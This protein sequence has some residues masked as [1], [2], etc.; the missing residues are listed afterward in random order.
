[1]TYLQ[2]IFFALYAVLV[3]STMVTVLLDNRQPAKAIAWILV[4]MFLPVIGIILYIFFGQNMR[5]ERLISGK[6]VGEV[7]QFPVSDT[8]TVQNLAQ[9][10]VHEK[11]IRQFETQNNALP[12]EGNSVE[13]YTD[14]YDHFLGMLKAIGRARHHIHLITYIIEDDP[15]GRLVA[16]ALADCVARGVEVRLIYDDVGCWRVPN[17]FFERMRQRG[18]Q[19]RAFMP[20]RFPALTSRINYRNHRKLCVV[21]GEVAFIG[22]MNIAMRYVKSWRDTHLC[23]SGNVVGALQR[24]FL[25]DWYFSMED[26]ERKPEELVERLEVE[27]GRL[28]S[29]LKTRK[30]DFSLVSRPELGHALAQLVTSSPV[31]EFPVL[32]LGYVRI[33]LQ[34]RDYVYMETPY[35]LPTEMILSAMRI[36]AQ[37]GVDVRLMVPRETDTY[38]VEWASRS[39][40]MEVVESGVTIYL[41]EG[42]FNHSK[43]LV[44][45]DSICTCGST[46]IDFRSFEHNFEA[47][48]FFY[49]AE[50]A[51]R[52]KQVFF[53][54]LQHCSR[55]EDELQ[56]QR[57]PFLHRLWESLLRLFSPLL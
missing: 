47:N 46:N 25:T 34:A 23:V 13:I 50:V 12:Y 32:M 7:T 51:S 45:D 2:W 29:G 5:K 35:F 52:F 43:L 17:S 15:L 18:I 8:P 3:A 33:L 36:A 38:V 20:V 27:I 10:S 53:D 41:Y 42:T 49:D 57:R 44:S 4:L 1:M 48:M 54:D 16:D 37:S 24:C 31:A 56:M 39:Y 40:L 14:G 26:Q 6:T 30:D 9:Q 55:I 22:G 19:V 11:L 21:D 28:E